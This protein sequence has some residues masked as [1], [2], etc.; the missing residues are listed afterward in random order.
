MQLSEN[1]SQDL[2]Q[3]YRKQQVDNP[4][5]DAPELWATDL[6]GQ[7]RAV[8]NEMIGRWMSESQQAIRAEIAESLHT[9]DMV[10]VHRPEI[11][12]ADDV[13]AAYRPHSAAGLPASPGGPAASSAAII[14]EEGRSELE[15]RK[16]AAQVMRGQYVEGASDLS[17]EIG[18]DH[19]RGFFKDPKLRQ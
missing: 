17:Q 4:G 12:G 9:P 6:S 11:D 5:L 10:D 18:Q 13:R 19:N 2:A 14:I 16:A 1:L 3:W 7:Q 15:G 8:R